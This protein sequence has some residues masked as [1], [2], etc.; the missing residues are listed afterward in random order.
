MTGRFVVDTG[1][2]KA[3]VVVAKEGGQFKVS[4]EML[5]LPMP[6]PAAKVVAEGN[7]LKATSTF[8]FMPGREAELVM[9]WDG[10]GY[11]L[12]GQHILLGPMSGKATPFAGKTMLEQILE[13][14]PTKKTGKVIKRT[15][16][17]IDQAVEALL[18]KMTLE[19]KIGQMSQSMGEMGGLLGAGIQNKLPLD[20]R[21]RQ[22]MVGSI[23]GMPVMPLM[24]QKQK[25]AVEESRLGI[26]LLFGKDVIHGDT[27]IFPI[28]LAWACS[29]NPQL[30]EKAA[31]IS[32]IE[33]AA[34]GITH[35]MAPMVDI[36]RDPRWGRV[37]E[38]AGEDPYLGSVMSVAQVKGYQGEDLYAP[39][40]MLAT[41][42]HYIG[43]GAAEG[44]RDYNTCEISDTTMRNAFLPPFRAGV[45][46]GAFCAMNSF[47]VINGV[48]MAINKPILND[49]LRD[50][51]GFD[52]FVISDYGSIDECVAHGAAEDVADAAK[53]AVIAGLDMEM[54]TTA[55]LDN[56]AALVEKGELDPGLIDISVSRI[57]R[58]KFEL[59][60]MDDPYKYFRPEVSAFCDEHLAASRE[61]ARESI[62]L[63]KNSGVLPLSKDKKIALVGPKGDSTDMLGPW[64]FTR[65]ANDTVTLKQG[66]ELAGYAVAYA[67]GSEVLT[68]ISNDSEGQAQTDKDSDTPSSADSGIAE[69]IAVAKDADVIILALG[70]TAAMSGEAASRQSIDI[71]EPQMQLAYAMK[72]LGK[73][74]ILVL[75]NGRPLLLNWF[76]ENADAIVETW[77]L[78]SEAGNAIADIISGDYNPSGKLSMTFPHHPGQIPLYY[79]HLNTGRPYKEGDKDKFLSRYLDGPNTPLYPFGYGLSYTQFE[80]SGLALSAD[81]MDK[82][83]EITASVKLRNAGNCGGTEVVQLYLRDVSASISRPVKELKG[84]KKVYLEPGEEVEVSFVITEPMLRFSNVHNVEVS[85]PGVFHVMIGNSS[86]DKDLEKGAFALI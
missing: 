57:L 23:N 10:E 11:N 5:A 4:L 38:G 14:L 39:D 52:G 17:E 22:G 56:L 50:E 31:R 9:E 26:P 3:L 43:Y 67:K 66:L 49:L 18:A 61:M 86:W 2:G 84:F 71:P 48:P 60:L 33:A 30:V 8:M 55:Y 34:A 83:S 68:P 12:S 63:L 24:Y 45:E 51:L 21:I 37:S 78:G 36:G 76:E 70:E 16:K 72:A 6:F 20:E 75:T 62:V 65:R 81:A 47:N 25:I 29:F 53:K 1:R 7:V 42:K 69:A 40:T 44:G 73:P 19:E 32:A 77:F 64:Q 28:P 85:E 15:R 13:E 27:T 59:G 80:I 58:A 54:A 82:S 35:N 46:A 79:N 74:I 41:L